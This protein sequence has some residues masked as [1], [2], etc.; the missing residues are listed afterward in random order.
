VADIFVSY[1]SRD[2]DWA[3]WIGQEDIVEPQAEVR[4]TPSG[5]ATRISLS[6]RQLV[7]A[8]AEPSKAANSEAASRPSTHK[9]CCVT[10]SEAISASPLKRRGYRT[11]AK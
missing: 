6:I 11:A 5:A 3:F 8:L 10:H 4:R 2:R 1:T 7:V 9:P